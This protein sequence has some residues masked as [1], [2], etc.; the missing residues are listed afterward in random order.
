M[1]CLLVPAGARGCSYKWYNESWIGSV[2]G[3]RWESFVYHTR[4]VHAFA[5]ME[6][7]LWSFI[8][9]TFVTTNFEDDLE[10]AVGGDG[11]T[12]LTISLDINH[13]KGATIRHKKKRRRRARAGTGSPSRRANRLVPRP[14]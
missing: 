13:L 14:P 11:V 2:V 4:F 10:P 12:A 7:H 3:G 8:N 1:C 6:E 5:G 9:N